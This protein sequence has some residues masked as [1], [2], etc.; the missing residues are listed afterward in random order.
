MKLHARLSLFAAVA[1]V[2]LA[3]CAKTPEARVAAEIKTF[4]EEETNAKLIGRGKAFASVGDYTR[5]E[6]YLAAALEQGADPKE[7]MPLLLKVCVAERRYRVAINY[8]EPELKKHPSNFHLRF[9]LAS[10]YATIGDTAAAHG[11]LQRVIEEKPSFAPVHFALAVLL[12][13]EEG[14]LVQ[15]DSHFR[16]YLR[17]D[18]DG[19]HAEEA[20]GS[21][22]K[23]KSD[24][25]LAPI[26]KTVP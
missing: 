2:A 19:S 13:D 4:Q 25:A 26:W 14:D 23:L 9:V 24:Q 22:L 12:R 5:A 6:Q 21:L 10:L 16:E 15:A 18:P 11:Q 8:A 20:R 1:V 3:A 17:L 7:V